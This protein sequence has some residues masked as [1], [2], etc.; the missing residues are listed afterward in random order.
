MENVIKTTF[1][2]ITG[3]AVHA[4]N[5][6]ASQ[7]AAYSTTVEAASLTVAAHLDSCQPHG[8]INKTLFSG[9]FL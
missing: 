9:L 8:V 1:T 6:T 4:L 7:F 5:N 3:Q 2:N